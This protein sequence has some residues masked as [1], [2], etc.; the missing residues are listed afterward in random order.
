MSTPLRRI[1]AD[2]YETATDSP[3]PG[4]TTHAY[5]WTRPTGNV[6]FYSPASDAQFDAFAAAGGIAHQYLSHQDEAGPM[7]AA[8]AARFGSRLHA[9][10]VEA[11][12]ITRHAGIDVPVAGRGVDSV[13]VEVIPTPGHTPGSTS[14]LV[15]GSAGQ[16]YL[17]TG[18][19]LF[20]RGDGTWGTFVIPGIGDVDAMRSSL[21]LLA[22]L[23][24]DVVLASAFAG[25][26]GY[27]EMT[28]R[29]WSHHVERALG[30][31][32]VSASR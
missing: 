11:E 13:G 18:D 6:L 24:P 10:A 23:T 20:P 8:L 1:R 31:L 7:L 29:Q 28:G 27:Q 14:Y 3:F 15:S 17:F 5:L 32:S 16:T 21:R 2:L 12:Q 22:T 25:D 26:A 30:E 9:P 19:T 4:L